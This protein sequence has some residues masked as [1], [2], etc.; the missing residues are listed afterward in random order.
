M[1]H[2]TPAT[3]WNIGGQM[4]RRAV[5]RR[6]NVMVPGWPSPAR[7][8]PSGCSPEIRIDHDTS[9]TVPVKEMGKNFIDVE[10]NVRSIQRSLIAWLVSAPIIRV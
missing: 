8:T 2:F 10:T 7:S 1:Q 4:L 9:G 5:A 6:T 3:R